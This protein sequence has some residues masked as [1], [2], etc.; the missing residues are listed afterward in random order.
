MVPI[1]LT[2]ASMQKQTHP[3]TPVMP[4]EDGDIRASPATLNAHVTL[5]VATSHTRKSHRCIATHGRASYHD[6]EAA[7]HKGGKPGLAAARLFAAVSQ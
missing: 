6:A 4:T 2:A 3:Q 5:L 7:E 1:I